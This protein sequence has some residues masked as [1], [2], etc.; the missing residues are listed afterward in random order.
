MG[1][2]GV[3]FALMVGSRV[4]VARKESGLTQ[5]MLSDELGFKDRQILANIEAG[6]RKVSTEAMI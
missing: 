4:R 2:G 6:K 5:K 3:D 1:Q